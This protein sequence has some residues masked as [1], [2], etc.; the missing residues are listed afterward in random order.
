LATVLTYL[1]VTELRKS[2]NGG[3]QGKSREPDEIWGKVRE[4][5]KSEGK[6]GNVADGQEK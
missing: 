1:V 3:S 5:R 4:L 6:L 2:G